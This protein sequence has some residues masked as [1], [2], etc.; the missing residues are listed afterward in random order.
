MPRLVW[1]SI[2][3]FV[4]PCRAGTTGMHHHTQILIAWAGLKRQSSQP[5]L[6]K[7]PIFTALNHHAWANQQL[8]Y[9]FSFLSPLHSHPP[10]TAKFLELLSS[11]QLQF[12]SISYQ[13]HKHAVQFSDL[14][15]LATCR[16]WHNWSFTYLFIYYCCTGGTLWHLQKLSQ[17]VIVEFIF[18][19]ILLYPPS[20][21]S[22]N[23]FNR[24]HF[25]FSGQLSE[26]PP[27][28]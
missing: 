8:E 27:F 16:V 20:H 11:H 7:W 17:Y 3:L 2:L 10:L 1:T 13:P 15:L 4:F 28:P 23:T 25:P 6:P 9:S 21:H 5:L 19:I 22:W 14:I 26:L 24:S 12:L 18:S